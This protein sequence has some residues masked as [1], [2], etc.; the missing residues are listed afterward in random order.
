MKELVKGQ[1]IRVTDLTSVTQ[2]GIGLQLTFPGAKALDISCFGV[3]AKQHL[4]DDRYFIFYNQRRSPCGGIVSHG[5]HEGDAEHFSIDLSRLPSSIQRLVFTATLDG[6]GTMSQLS[7]GY[8]RLVANSLEV[9]RY[10]FAGADFGNEAALIVGELYLKD[11]WRFGAVGQGFNGGLSAL[12]KHF[13]GEEVG[14]PSPPPPVIPIISLSKITLEKKGDKK[15]VSLRKD[16]N[17]QRIHFNLNWDNPNKGKRT[18]FLGLGSET[19]APDLDLGCMYKL[20]NGQKG[21]IQ[22]LGKNFGA[23]DDL[24]FIFL[25]KDDRS[26]AAEDGENLSILRPDLIDMVMVFAF[27]YEGT[28]DFTSVNGRMTI[29]DQQGNEIFIRLN[30]PSPNLRF[31]AICTIKGYADTVEIVKEELYFDGHEKAD[32]HFEFGFQWRVGKKD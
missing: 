20:K 2:F 12:L 32:N 25:D 29:T 8:I 27:I 23:K 19:A 13:G 6:G 21:V 16:G 26:G 5:A 1:K 4:S 28:S 14:A 15:A 22:P 10:R 31:C 18:G 24:P 11:G 30:N 9:M 7:Q 17:K 3:D